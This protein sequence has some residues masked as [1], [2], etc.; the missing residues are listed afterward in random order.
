DLLAEVQDYLT[1]R[2][3]CHAHVIAANP[4]F[5][6]LRMKFTVT[7][8]KGYNDTSY[9]RTLLRNEIT[10]YLT[11]WAFGGTADIQFGGKAYKSSLI[12]FVE[13]RPYVDFLTCVDL[14]HTAGDGATES[15]D[16]EEVVAST[17]RSILV[18][19]PASRH[20]IDVLAH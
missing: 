8:R 15:K 3:S 11:P 10:Q 2:T 16:L 18:S 7:L 5:E 19:A 4:L 12:D 1:A 9:Y 6:E 17:A 13:E 14:Y 20:D